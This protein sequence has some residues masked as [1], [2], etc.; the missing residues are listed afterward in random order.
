MRPLIVTALLLLTLTA[1]AAADWQ[2]YYDDGKIVASY[3][4]LSRAPF[5]EQPSLWVR[6]HYAAPQDGVGGKKIEFTAQCSEHRLFEV[7]TIPY[8]ANGNYLEE[9]D[10]LK[11]P[12]EVPVDSTPLAKATYELLCE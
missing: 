6:W 7:R 3:D 10:H 9:S 5:R 4:V 1:S 11:T 8:D 12:K 2:L